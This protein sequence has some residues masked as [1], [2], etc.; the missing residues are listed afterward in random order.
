MKSVR[1]LTI[2]DLIEIIQ[3]TSDEIKSDTINDFRDR[4][5]DQIYTAIKEYEDY[6][7][8]RKHSLTDDFYRQI[9]EQ[10]RQALSL[11]LLNA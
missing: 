7:N 3:E 10:F 9:D 1:K 4:L 2:D 8:S 11:C 5:L 6:I